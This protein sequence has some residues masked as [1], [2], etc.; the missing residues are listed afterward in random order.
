MSLTAIRIRTSAWLRYIGITLSIAAA[1]AAG[2]VRAQPYPARPVTIVVPLSGGSAT[3]GMTRILAE[4]LS[5]KWGQ[6]VIVLNKPG[7]SGTIGTTYVARSPADGY[8]L[9]AMSS[10]Q[11]IGDSLLPERPVDIKTAL[12]PIVSIGGVPLVLCVNDAVPANSVQGLIDLAKSSPGRLNYGSPGVG[13]TAHIAAALFA[14]QTSIA[15]THVPY[16]AVSQAQSGLASGQIDLMFIIPSV[17]RQL[18]DLGKIRCLLTNSVTRIPLFPDLPTMK[19]TGLS[20]FEVDDWIGLV[21]PAGMPEEVARKISADVLEAIAKP[22]VRKRIE[23]VGMIEKPLPYDEFIS[24]YHGD[25]SRWLHVLKEI[26]L[27]TPTR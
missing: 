2:P 5:K 25:F 6:G 26:G 4:Q 19:E 20:D 14:R 10:N 22:D 9:L 15:L 7:G 8:T 12:R 18:A 17:A 1:S 23:N 24:R 21:G 13:S 16:S 11:V 27:I 3:D